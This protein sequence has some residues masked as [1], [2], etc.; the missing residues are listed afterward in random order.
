MASSGISILNAILDS[1]KVGS[2]C[3]CCPCG[4]YYVVG[5]VETFL[6]F[7]ESTDWMNLSETCEGSRN[8]WYNSC[9][10][11]TCFDKFS[12]IG[13][14][15]ANL[16]LTKGYIEYSS[17][18]NKSM[19]CLL[20]DYIIENNLSE[21]EGMEII[22]NVLDKGI[23]FYCGKDQ[24]LENGNQSNQILASV[25]TFLSFYESTFSCD[26]PCSCYPQEK[27]CLNI[28]SNTEEYVKWAEFSNE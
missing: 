2:L 9:C 14:D 8:A 15:I 5:S 18:G 25:E 19:L 28:L 16:I 4:N 13:E 11:E 23:V 20:Y 24:N 3:D 17:L 21:E 22:E 12:E 7:L 1:G 27:C 26:D 6:Q 10:T